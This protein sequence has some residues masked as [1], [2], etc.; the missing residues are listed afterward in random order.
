MHNRSNGQGKRRSTNG[1]GSA[2]NNQ[3]KGGYGARRIRECQRKQERGLQLAK[4]LESFLW[5]G[6]TIKDFAL[7]E[8]L[9]RSSA[10]RIF[11]RHLAHLSYPRSSTHFS[12]MVRDQIRRLRAA[13]RPAREIAELLKIKPQCVYNIVHRYGPLTETGRTCVIRITTLAERR[14]ERRAARDRFTL[15]IAEQT[16]K[17]R[18]IG[19]TFSKIAAQYGLSYHDFY[20]QLRRA[21]RYFPD[22]YGQIRSV[23]RTEQRGRG[24]TRGRFRVMGLPALSYAGVSA[25]TDRELNRETQTE[26]S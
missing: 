15:G 19:Y 23:G 2:Q 8:G 11:S 7:H 6:K 26:V 22:Q 16:M 17:L 10:S 4:R 9:S 14:I 3:R 5:E 13:G 24:R 25:E 12:A 20:N 1:E 21:E 18:Q